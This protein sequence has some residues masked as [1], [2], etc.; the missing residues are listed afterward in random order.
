MRSEPCPPSAT[1]LPSPL[2]RTSLPSAERRL[3]VSGAGEDEVV[4]RTAGDVVVAGA[5]KV[6]ERGQRLSREHGKHAVQVR[7]RMEKIEKGGL[8]DPAGRAGLS[9]NSMPFP[10]SVGSSRLRNPKVPGSAL[11]SSAILARSTTR[12]S[13][14][15]WLQD[16][17]AGLE[18][19]VDGVDRGI[20][21]RLEFG[22][23][24]VGDREETGGGQRLEDDR[25]DPLL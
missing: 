7:G 15:C 5:A 14:P 6:G 10:S 1:S 23:K 25:A 18:P 2:N 22:R 19:L 16:E 8:L 4:A 24:L 11:I 17:R 21:D 12:T 3:I 9:V 20:A 13:R